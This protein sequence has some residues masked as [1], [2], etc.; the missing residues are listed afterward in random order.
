MIE[1]CDEIM[2]KVNK[3]YEISPLAFKIG[4]AAIS[5]MLYEASCSPTPGLVSPS[6]NGVHR[7]MNF[8]TFLRSTAAIA[9][10]MYIC[11]QI[12]IDYETDVLKK[13]RSVGINA[14][15]EMLKATS[16]VNTQSGLLFVGGIVC[17]SAGECIHKG[18]EVNR[19]NISKECKLIGAGIVKRELNNIDKNKKPTNGELIYLKYGITGIRGEI[20]NGLPC[21][22]DIG[23]PLYEEGIKRNIGV[24]KA[25]VHSLIGIMTVIDDTVVINKTDLLGLQFMREEA[26]N[27]MELGGMLTTQG[28]AYIKSME[29]KFE[30][31]NISPGG[32]ADLLAISV[33][34]YELENAKKKGNF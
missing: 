24:N 18:I 30:E 15:K 13:I 3:G 29:S 12:G 2:Q 16:G 33:M 5:G 6:S 26:R 25:L 10:A 8:F 27:A 4:E 32:A 21:V 34:I 28:E 7:D 22:I 20:E 14:E 1:Y 19:Y 23:L 17:A 31:K 9:Y 11:A